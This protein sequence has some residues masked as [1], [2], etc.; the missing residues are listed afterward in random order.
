MKIRKGL[1]K[2]LKG[3]FSVIKWSI[4]FSWKTSPCYTM[5]RIGGAICVPVTLY[6]WSL[7]LFNHHNDLCMKQY[8]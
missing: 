5:I 2:Y 7:D 8:R 3:Y 1:F 6:V 4:P